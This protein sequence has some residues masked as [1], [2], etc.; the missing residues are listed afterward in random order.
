MEATLV[1]ASLTSSPQGPASRAGWPGHRC[2]DGVLD[3]AHHDLAGRLHRGRADLRD[4]AA[5]HGGLLAM[6][7]VPLE[8]LAHHERHS[9]CVV[10]LGGSIAATRPQVGDERRARRDGVEVVDV[11]IDPELVGDGQQVQHAVGGAAGGG[12]RGDAVLEGRAVDDVRGPHITPHQIHDQLAAAPRGSVLGGVL[13]GDAVEAGRG[14]AM[15]SR[16]MDM[17]LAVYWP[18]QAPAP[19][20]ALFSIS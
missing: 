18:L 19:G 3:G 2:L 17:V 13:G 7:Q 10:Q 8:Q 5:I 20:Q 16:T 6:Q 15:N 9:A 14:Q 12:D 11:Q 1:A 4:G